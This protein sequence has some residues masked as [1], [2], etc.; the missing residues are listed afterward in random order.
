MK[1]DNV[2]CFFRIEE[3]GPTLASLFIDEITYAAGYY[4]N[5]IPEE[6][7]FKSE[8]IYLIHDSGGSSPISVSLF[9]LSRG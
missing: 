7:N 9:H 2:P 3:D 8:E 1:K 5:G 6:I 4:Q